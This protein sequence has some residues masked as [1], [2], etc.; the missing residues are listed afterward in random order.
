MADEAMADETMGEIRIGFS[1]YTT[2]R[3]MVYVS[4]AYDGIG[5]VIGDGEIVLNLETGAARR[6]AAELIR[7]ADAENAR[8]AEH[9]K[10][11]ADALADPAS[12]FNSL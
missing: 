10:V 1:H 11:M 5:A 7:L 3:L 8:T 4:D 2:A 12:S 9:D 6:F